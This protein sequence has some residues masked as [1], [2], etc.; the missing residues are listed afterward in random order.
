MARMA[1]VANMLECR[2]VAP[3]AAPQVIVQSKEVLAD[4]MDASTMALYVASVQHAL[5]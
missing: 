4:A 3:E 1:R 2:A 5:G